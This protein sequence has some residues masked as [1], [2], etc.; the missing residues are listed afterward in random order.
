MSRGPPQRIDQWV[1]AWERRFRKCG[2]RESR[3][4]SR[5][6]L[7]EWTKK[8]SVRESAVDASNKNMTGTIVLSS[9]RQG[10]LRS[11]GGG[12]VTSQ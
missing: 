1:Q 5:S 4:R 2:P 11:G 12:G 8:S 3:E 10:V 6:C 9:Y 7:Q